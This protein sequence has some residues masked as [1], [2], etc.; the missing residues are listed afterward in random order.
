MIESDVEI[1][2]SVENPVEKFFR[3]PRFP[4]CL[5]YTAAV[6]QKNACYGNCAQHHGSTRSNGILLGRQD[7]AK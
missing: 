1:Q 7:A 3:R 5:Q 6:P 2:V 4:L